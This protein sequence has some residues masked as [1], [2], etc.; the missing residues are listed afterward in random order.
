MKSILDTLFLKDSIIIDGS[1]FVDT[2][3]DV[4]CRDVTAEGDVIIGSTSSP[5]ST[6]KLAIIDETNDIA[7]LFEY[8]TSGHFLR[9]YLAR[10]T[11]ASPSAAQADDALF[12]IAARGYHS[13]TDWSNNIAQIGMFAKQNLTAGAQGSYITFGVTPSGSTTIAEAWRIESDKLLYSVNG[14]ISVGASSLDASAILELTSTT[15]GFLPPRMTT[16]QRDAIGSPAEGLVI[17][18]DDDDEINIYTTS[19][20]LI[21]AA[22]LWTL[23]GSDI[24]YNTG[25]AGV[26]DTSVDASS[27]FEL[28]ST[29]KGFLKP[30]MTTTQ[31]NAIS[32]PATGLEVYDTNFLS[33]FQYDGSNWIEVG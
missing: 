8:S 24:Y 5:V 18:N 4:T 3:R 32:S 29:T 10:G 1:T 7:R 19:W 30:R 14:G 16:A 6:P 22:G 26:G 33:T 17:Y 20:G 31:R 12:A 2:D 11:E 28:T 23:T 25:S 15:K 21:S 9:T 13:G 27:I